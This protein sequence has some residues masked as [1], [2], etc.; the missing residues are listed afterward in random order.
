MV[1]RGGVSRCCWSYQSAGDGVLAS[2]RSCGHTLSALGFLATFC[3]LAMCLLAL[4]MDTWSNIEHDP[5]F[6]AQWADGN[7]GLYHYSFEI[8]NVTVYVNETLQTVNVSRSGSMNRRGDDTLCHNEDYNLDKEDSGESELD[9]CDKMIDACADG[10]TLGIAGAVLGG[11]GV[12]WAAA[13]TY[14]LDFHKA[15]HSKDDADKTCWRFCPRISTGGIVFSIIAALLVWAG[16]WSYGDQ[17]PES[18]S[19]FLMRAMNNV[20]FNT[21]CSVYKQGLN[22]S[23]AKCPGMNQTIAIPT[24]CSA[25]CSVNFGPDLQCYLQLVITHASNR[26]TNASIA[27]DF[28]HTADQTFTACTLMPPPLHLDSLDN[29][30]AW[31]LMLAAGLVWLGAA[32]LLIMARFYR[33]LLNPMKMKN[34]LSKPLVGEEL[35]QEGVYDDDVNNLSYMPHRS[36]EDKVDGMEIEAD[37]YKG[38]DDGTQY[39]ALL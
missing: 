16:C 10:S 29:S 6:P 11:L 15:Q 30:T 24:N 1:L 14:T 31:Y 25:N 7:F 34:S 37:Y 39:Q 18:A 23:L 5:L 33:K 17:R 28:N 20:T 38:S 13:S 3:G 8:R 27:Q 9:A 19:F 21:T 4:H 2:Q 36:S 32:G 12:L 35:W 26:S 22:Q